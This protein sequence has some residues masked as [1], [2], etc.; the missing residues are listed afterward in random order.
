MSGSSSPSSNPQPVAPP[1]AEP[2][3]L[4]YDVL[5][6][7]QLGQLHDSAELPLSVGELRHLESLGDRVSHSEVSSV[8]GPLS[9]LIRLHIHSSARLAGARST[10]LGSDLR[11]APFVIG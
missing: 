6:P 9:E 7:Q 11:V 4:L 3:Q 5:S 8:Y 1:S 2:A 10:L